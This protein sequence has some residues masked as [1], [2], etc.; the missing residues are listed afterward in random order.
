LIPL[1]VEQPVTREATSWRATDGDLAIWTLATLEITSSLWRL[2]RDG[3]LTTREV[4][5]A[6][7]RAD[8]LVKRATEVVDLPAVK[9]LGRRMLRV[10]PLRAADAMQ[11]AAAMTWAEGHPSGLVLHTFDRRL[12]LAAEREGFVVVPAPA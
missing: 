4:R 6:E 2:Q 5:E 8:E 9:E 12:G 11:L 1:L 7:A 3:A 10:H